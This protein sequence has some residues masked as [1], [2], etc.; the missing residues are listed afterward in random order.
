MMCN[1]YDSEVF[2]CKQAGFYFMSGFPVYGRSPF[3]EDDHRRGTDESSGYSD[4]LTLAAP[5]LV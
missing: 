3:V 1:C 4:A 2:L 5:V